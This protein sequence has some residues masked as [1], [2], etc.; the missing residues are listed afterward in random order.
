MQIE[1]ALERFIEQLRANGRSHHTTAQVSRHA[2]ALARWLRVR[3]HTTRVEQITH[4]LVARFFSSDGAKSRADGRARKITTMN[5]HRGSLKNFL[6]FLHRAGYTATDAGRL[7]QRAR[8][9]PGR[10]SG[11]PRTERAR[12][13]APA[14]SGSGRPGCLFPSGL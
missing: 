7:I 11:R 10:W 13:A 2:L 1:E 4:E 3:G 6:G 14:R 5:A 8:R 12:P 9:R